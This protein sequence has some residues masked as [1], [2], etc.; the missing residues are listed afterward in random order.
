[1]KK[2]VKTSKD[3][4]IEVQ[5]I[6]SRS[7]NLSDWKDV[8]TRA[9]RWKNKKTGKAGVGVS[10]VV[11]EKKWN[12]EVKAKV[13]YTDTA[14]LGDNPDMLIAVGQELVKYGEAMKKGQ[15]K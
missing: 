4:D 14:K 13:V 10:L 5:T 11:D 9:Y 6:S 1:M 3:N 12:P 2:D 7:W 8:K 15:F